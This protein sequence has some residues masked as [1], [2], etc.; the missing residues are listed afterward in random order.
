MTRKHLRG[1]W[2]ID[3]SRKRASPSATKISGLQLLVLEKVPVEKNHSFPKMDD[4]KD[5]GGCR[6]PFDGICIFHSHLR[7]EASSVTWNILLVKYSI[8]TRKKARC[9]C[10]IMTF[11]LALGLGSSWNVYKPAC[12]PAV[13]AMLGGVLGRL[14]KYLYSKT[15][16]TLML[17]MN[18]TPWKKTQKCRRGHDFFQLVSFSP[19]S[20]SGLDYVL[21]LEMTIY[22]AYDICRS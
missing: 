5:M 6:D 12:G 22:L 16:S 9:S 11:E 15:Y 20:Q 13:K 14:L 4:P 17:E 10:V 8:E 2:V 21:E 18:I 1:N 19:F 3:R 7:G